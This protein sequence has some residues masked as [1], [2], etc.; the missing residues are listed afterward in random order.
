MP[1]AA[2]AQPTAKPVEAKTPGRK[3]VTIVQPEVS[4]RRVDK[5]T[6][7]NAVRDSRV[8]D[9]DDKLILYTMDTHAK[10]QG[11]DVRPGFGLLA[12]ETGISDKTLRRR[13]AD[14]VRRGW[15]IQLTSGK[16]GNT[17]RTSA[18]HLAM[19]VEIDVEVEANRSPDD[20]LGIEANR[21]SEGANRSSEGEPIGHQDDLTTS[22]EQPKNNPSSGD[23]DGATKAT[24]KTQDPDWTGNGDNATDN[25]AWLAGLLGVPVGSIGLPFWSW[26]ASLGINA[27]SDADHGAVTG[28]A[29]RAASAGNPAGYF[30]SSLPSYL[31]KAAEEDAAQV[32]ANPFGFDPMRDTRAGSHDAEPWEY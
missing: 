8:L 31:E 15:L 19:P 3:Q 26:L 5:F 30:R 17:K 11:H 2:L 12:E 7:M 1:S 23:G 13:V 25:R 4:S 10:Q 28:A 29:K 14:L 9:K 22:Q 21:S 18:Y 16:G 32:A 27:K 24:S 6:H 20:L